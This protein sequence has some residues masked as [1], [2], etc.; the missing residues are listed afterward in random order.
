MLK[1][2]RRHVEAEHEADGLRLWGGAG[3]VRLHRVE[4][5]PDTIVQLLEQC[6][7]G[8]TLSARPEAEQ[9]AVIASLLPRLWVAPPVGHRFRSLGAM[10]EQWAAAAER[11]TASGAAAL[12]PGLVRAGLLLFRALPASAPRQVVLCTDLHAGNVLAARPR[13]VAGDRPQAAC[14]RPHLRRVQHLL[15]CPGRLTP[16][17]VGWRRRMADLLD[18]DRERLAL[19]LFARCV[20]EA[21]EWPELAAVAHALAPSS[22]RVQ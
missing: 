12:D 3:A 22:T 13:A 8:T 11:R 1:V 7:P 4:E 2:A 5:A 17:R 20:Q 10:C 16:T 9:D 6:V 18:L 14:R 21:P 19:W 15:N